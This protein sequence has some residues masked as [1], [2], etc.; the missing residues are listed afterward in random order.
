MAVPTAHMVAISVRD[1]PLTEGL[2][3]LENALASTIA[4]SPKLAAPPTTPSR[5][6]WLAMSKRNQPQ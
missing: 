3:A 5:T 1:V 6:N 2:P 4:K